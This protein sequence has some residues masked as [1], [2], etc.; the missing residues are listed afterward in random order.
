MLARGVLLHATLHQS[1]AQKTR[2]SKYER[3]VLVS[4][5]LLNNASN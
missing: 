1:S 3:G 2:D 5:F 4:M